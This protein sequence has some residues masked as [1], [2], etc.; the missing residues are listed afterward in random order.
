MFYNIL[1]VNIN[2]YIEQATRIGKRGYRRPLRIDLLSRRMTNH[3]LQNAYYFKNTGYAVSP[4]LDTKSLEER[5]SL[6]ENMIRA[7]RE[8]K[9]ATIRNN[10]LFINGKEHT[11]SKREHSQEFQSESHQVTLSSSVYIPQQSTSN[12]QD[13]ETSIGIQHKDHNPHNSFRR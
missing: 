10:K 13:N 5:K 8:G 6:R 1:N 12:T 11:Y 3:V 2:G 7:R 9:H 4:L